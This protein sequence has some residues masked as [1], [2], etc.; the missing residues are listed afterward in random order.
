MLSSLKHIICLSLLAFLIGN[1]VSCQSWH[2]A[3]EV[4]AEADSLLA[5]G[6][7]MRDTVVLASSIRTLDNFIGRL[8]ERDK[9]AKAYYLMG[10]NL[11][12]YSHNFSDAAEYYIAADRIKTKDYVL[13]GRINSCMGFLCKQ[14]SCFEEALV[15]Y[16]R[17]NEAFAKSGN[18]KRYANGL[19]SIAE[20]Y[21]NLKEY[22]KADSVLSL[23]DDYEIDSALYARKIDVKALACYNQQMYDSALVY[24]LSIK[25]YPRNLEARCFSYMK[26]MHNHECINQ[27]CNNKWYAEYIVTHSKNSNY[28]SNAYFYLM[29]L[30]ELN[31][32]IENLSVYSHAREDEDR[33]IRNANES[34]A[35]ATMNLKS[36]LHNP[37]PSRRI[38]Y[39]IFALCAL[40]CLLGVLAYWLY[41]RYH[42]TKKMHTDTLQIHENEKM[43]RRDAYLKRVCNHSIHFM[44]PDVWKNDQR[45][46]ESANLHFSDMFTRLRDTYHLSDQEIKICLMILLEYSREQMATLLYL[47]PNTISKAKNKIAKDLATTSVHLRD[48][49]IDFLSR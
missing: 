37:Y 17:A 22:T 4:I 14:D 2:E 31:N 5:K 16:E 30:A 34:C 32:D 28:R 10:R 43:E 49:L 44:K 6:V 13:R 35:Q 8:C 26:I 39:Y 48:F 45:L 19:V 1:F 47:Q 23:A 3:K 9:L 7:I 41:K 15:F 27:L 21:V 36:Y 38:T 42:L 12:D 29:I 40:L 25:E 18:D 20:Q 11:D 24:L 46:R 33:N